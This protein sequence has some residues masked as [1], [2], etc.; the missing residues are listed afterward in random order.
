VVQQEETAQAW[1]SRKS[2][3][4]RFAAQEPEQAWSAKKIKNHRDR[5]NRAGTSDPNPTQPWNN[6]S[7]ETSITIIRGQGNN[8]SGESATNHNHSE[9]IDVEDETVSQHKAYG[10]IH[11]GENADEQ[12]A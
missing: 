10:A 2:L 1:R 3:H 6:I 4:K 11:L 9:K 5:A 7:R 8:I 12:E